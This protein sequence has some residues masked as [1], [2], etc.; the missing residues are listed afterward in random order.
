MTMIYYMIACMVAFLIAGLA[1]C[2]YIYMWAYSRMLRYLLDAIMAL[3]VVALSVI[4][5]GYFYRNLFGV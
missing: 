2:H 3:F 5:F 4:A 1:M